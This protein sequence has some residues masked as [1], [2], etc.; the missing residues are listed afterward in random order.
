MIRPRRARIVPPLGAA[1][2]LTRAERLGKPLDQTLPALEDADDLAVRA[3]ITRRPTGTDDRVQPG[4][5]RRL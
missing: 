2:D 4:R 1:G 5:L 3:S